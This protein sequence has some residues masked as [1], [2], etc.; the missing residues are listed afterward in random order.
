MCNPRQFQDFRGTNGTVTS[1]GYPEPYRYYRKQCTLIGVE[2]QVGVVM[3]YKANCHYGV[4][5][6]NPNEL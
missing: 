5:Y 1:P 6:F 3:G 2:G 4:H